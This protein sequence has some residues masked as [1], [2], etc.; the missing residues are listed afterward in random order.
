VEVDDLSNSKHSSKEID[1]VE[2]GEQVSIYILEL[3]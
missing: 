1:H 2:T 3:G